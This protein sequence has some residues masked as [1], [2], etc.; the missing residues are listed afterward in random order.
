M[1]NLYFTRLRAILLIILSVIISVS[2]VSLPGTYVNAENTV[3]YTDP[4]SKLTFDLAGDNTATLTGIDSS[5]TDVTIPS[6]VTKDGTD[7]TVTSVNGKSKKYANVK[8]IK[9]PSTVKTVEKISLPGMEGQI[10]FPSG[11]E[12]ISSF[13]SGASSVK[14]PNTLKLVQNIDFPNVTSVEFPSSVTSMNGTLRF[15]KV[16]EITIP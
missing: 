3:T 10:V 16:K 6:V 7:Y 15:K 4:A 9:F 1:K 14:F 12:E 5:L 8:S 11:V 2:M 13:T